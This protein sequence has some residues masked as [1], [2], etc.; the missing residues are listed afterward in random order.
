MLLKDNFKC[1]LDVYFTFLSKKKTIKQTQ[2]SVDIKKSG[3]VLAVGRV[4]VNALRIVLEELRRPEGPPTG[5]PYSYRKEKK[6]HWLIF[7]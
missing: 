3:P 7:S 2:N 1:I 5:A 6:P 4:K